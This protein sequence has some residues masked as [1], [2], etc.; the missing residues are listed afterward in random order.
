MNSLKNPSW[1]TGTFANWTVAGNIFIYAD[2]AYPVHTGH[3][4]MGTN[5]DGNITQTVNIA[6]ANITECSIWVYGDFTLGLGTKITV[7]FNYSDLTS[8]QFIHTTNLGESATW[9]KLDMIGSLTA[10]KTVVSIILA[11][12]FN[13]GGALIFCDDVYMDGG[14][15]N[16]SGSGSKKIGFIW[17][18][19]SVLLESHKP[20]VRLFRNKTRV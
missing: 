3:Y 1:E 6:V 15:P 18:L 13:G 2:P 10:G 9:V 20:P 19:L 16:I 17:F 7:T 8:S 11:P 4:S 12:S 5:D 14:P